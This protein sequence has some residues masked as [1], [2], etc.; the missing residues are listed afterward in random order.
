MFAEMS[1]LSAVAVTYDVTCCEIL[2]LL[3][4]HFVASFGCRAADA[5]TPHWR[6]FSGTSGCPLQSS[7]LAFSLL[8]S[9]TKSETETL[10]G[11]YYKLC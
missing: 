5:L 2:L 11:T 8:M 3:T 4:L 6:H 9:E 10:D 1:G 7:Q